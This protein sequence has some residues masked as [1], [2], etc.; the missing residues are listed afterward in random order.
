MA[1]CILMA[2]LKSK[3]TV[4]LFCKTLTVSARKST[5]HVLLSFSSC[6]CKP[7]CFHLTLFCCF[8]L[9]K[10]SSINPH[11]LFTVNVFSIY[12]ISILAFRLLCTSIFVDYIL[13]SPHFRNSLY[14]G[15]PSDCCA[16]YK[17]EKGVVKTKNQRNWKRCADLAIAWNCP[18]V[19]RKCIFNNPNYDYWRVY[20]II[21]Q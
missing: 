7:Y 11:A 2:L 1:E 17:M 3:C 8:I 15:P 12:F 9:M 14:G 19:A 6:A 5:L 4:L 21:N 18:A 20:C 10:N 13:C 16:E